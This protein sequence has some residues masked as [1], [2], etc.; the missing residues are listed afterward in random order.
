MDTNR[1]FLFALIHFLSLDIVRHSTVS[2]YLCYLPGLRWT[3]PGFC[4]AFVWL[5][6]VGSPLQFVAFSVDW[7]VDWLFCFPCTCVVFFFVDRS[8]ELCGS[9]P[10][11][12][13]SHMQT[14]PYAPTIILIVGRASARHTSRHPSIE[15]PQLNRTRLSMHLSCLCLCFS[16]KR[17]MSSF[18]L[19]PPVYV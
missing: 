17:K 4:V 11:S 18:C 6:R 19:L 16:R 13:R 3:Q 2:L 10:Y 14:L 5:L 9:C 8:C 15:S 1:L 7:L 12:M